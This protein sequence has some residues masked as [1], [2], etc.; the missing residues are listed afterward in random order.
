MGWPL[1]KDV[2]QKNPETNFGKNSR[3]NKSRRKTKIT[4]EGELGKDSAKLLRTQKWGGGQREHIGV[5]GGKIEG[6]SWPGNGP[7]S[8]RRRKTRSRKTKKKKKK[9]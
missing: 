1:S 7:K 5:S 9:N 3:T 4:W 6:T 2:L 8:H